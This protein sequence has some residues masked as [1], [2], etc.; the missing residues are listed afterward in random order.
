MKAL[1]LIAC[2]GGGVILLGV[3]YYLTLN[4]GRRRF[5]REQ[6]SQARHMLSRYFV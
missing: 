6:I 2:I 5:V 1:I 3:L 4:R